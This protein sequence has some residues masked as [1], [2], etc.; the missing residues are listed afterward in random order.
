MS[1]LVFAITSGQPNG[2]APIRKSCQFCRSRKIRCSGDRIC[3]AC[4]F[5]NL[6]C[7]YGREATKGRPRTST[8]T[9]S[10]RGPLPHDKLS[11]DKPCASASA[12]PSRSDGTYALLQG[13]EPSMGRELERIFQH[14]FLYKASLQS[15]NPRPINGIAPDSTYSALPFEP[16][17]YDRLYFGITQGLVQLI[18][19]QY[20]SL[21][22]C[23][24]PDIPTWYLA[25]S[26]AHDSTAQM[27]DE[28]G[29]Q[30]DL[31]NFDEHHV[32]Q[33]IE[34]FFIHNPL[35]V[36]ISKTLLLHDYRNGTHDKA[37]LALILADANNGLDAGP[38]QG[39]C[40]LCSRLLQFA[41]ECLRTRSS[42]NVSLST[43]QTL[44]LI[45]W[46]MICTSSGRR[47][48]CY[49]ELA[50]VFTYQFQANL[51]ASPK[52]GTDRVNGVDLNDVEFELVQRIYWLTFALE[53]WAALQMSTPLCD[54]MP[55]H[56]PM[57]FP[58]LTRDFSSVLRLDRESG[59][60][61]AVRVQEKFV[62]QLWPLSHIASTIAPIYAMCSRA[63]LS[64]TSDANSGWESHMLMNF[65][66]LLNGSGN[67]S[68]M[69]A[70]V[71]LV[72]SGGLSKLQDEMYNHPSQ[73]FAFSAYS[74]MVIHLLFPRSGTL[75][76][77]ININKPILDEVLQYMSLFKSALCATELAATVEPQIIEAIEPHL[78]EILILGID[79]CSRVL[80]K[81]FSKRAFGP[82]ADQ[83]LIDPYAPA[84]SE[85]SKAFHAICK[86]PKLQKVANARIVKKRLKMFHFGFQ[87]LNSTSIES[88]EH[89]SPTV[90][91]SQSDP[92]W[93]SANL[94]STSDFES[95]E[96]SDDVD[97][98]LQWATVSTKDLNQGYHLSRPFP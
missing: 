5:R 84:L 34:L 22:Y 27:F 44:V 96:F 68:H 16:I 85:L 60:V 31:P 71:R 79:T 10:S 97:V 87:R 89:L 53:L 9:T 41:I 47:G 70:E 2:A 93:P 33:M 26:L 61:A 17:T 81:L 39:D 67:L 30:I 58:P 75:H 4:K 77:D 80:E 38:K 46:H 83:E 88:S 86:H 24:S 35:S 8:A 66:R 98:D 55:L 11:R 19:T 40:G 42:K 6:N 72:L 13:R 3:S 74:V 20:G 52:S 49:I 62:W 1:D 50:R 59:N 28:V 45:G 95:C 92:E 18:L 12:A 14:E 25:R 51:A 63:S 91:L 82:A 7:V 48:Y 65:E 78:V 94:L 15:T 37:L 76:A 29:S 90:A 56:A 36:I 54:K 21:G 73:V 57:G 32:H 69:C 64:R 43:I 23:E